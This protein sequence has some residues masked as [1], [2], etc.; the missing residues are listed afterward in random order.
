[1]DR[2]GWRGT[3]GD[4][5]GVAWTGSG[6]LG[7]VGASGAGVEAL[8]RG[9]R[10]CGNP[11]PICSQASIYDPEREERE[12]KERE[13]D[14]LTTAKEQAERANIHDVGCCCFLPIG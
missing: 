6:G 12:E 9:R 3:A 5:F 8:W 14:H 13:G 2:K 10:R 11:T 4:Y 7:S 1:M